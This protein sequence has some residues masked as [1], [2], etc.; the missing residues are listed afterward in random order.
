VFESRRV[1]MLGYQVTY[2][3]KSLSEMTLKE[4]RLSHFFD[5]SLGFLDL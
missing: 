1:Q 5:S 2:G 3:M 4:S